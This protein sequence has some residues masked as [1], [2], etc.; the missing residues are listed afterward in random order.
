MDNQF[1]N[2]CG[3]ANFPNAPVCT[4]CG[5]ALSGSGSNKADFQS[6]PPTMAASRSVGSQSA[7]PEKKSK[8]MY[9]I[10][11]GVAALLLFAVGLV[12]LVA[13][14]IFVYTNN[15][16]D[17]VA[18]DETELQHKETNS[19]K[20][21]D[22]DIF[23][24]DTKDTK[25]KSDNPMDDISFPSGNDIDFGEKPDGN[26]SSLDN[27]ALVQFFKGKKSK[28]GI[29]KLVNVVS[30]NDKTIFA[31]RLA[32]VQANYSSGRKRIIHRL[33]VYSSLNEAK[34]DIAAYKAAVK[35]IRGRIRSSKAD[36]IIYSHKG[37]VYLAFYNQ[38][39][40]LHEISSK[41]G[42]DI[43]KYYNSYFRN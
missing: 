41:S 17:E 14:G 18:R 19:K 13:I 43:I 6:P 10:I 4:K 1:C 16:S 29:F 34:G 33:A 38:Q 15:Q 20:D 27:A 39:G 11:G 40:G 8:T 7:T 2:K 9:W 26:K 32:G 24:D 23:S 31:K 5:E 36:Q 37:L 21:D 12:I 35:K 25:T 22:T 30:S 3:Q 28:V 42:N